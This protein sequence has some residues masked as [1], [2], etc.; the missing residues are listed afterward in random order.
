MSNAVHEVKRRHANGM[1]LHKTPTKYVNLVDFG[2]VLADE[3][4]LGLEKNTKFMDAE[5]EADDNS[6]IMEDILDEVSMRLYGIL[7]LEECR[8]KKDDDK[9]I[10][11]V[12]VNSKTVI[13]TIKDTPKKKDILTS[14]T[15]KV[16]AEADLEANPGFLW[17]AAPLAQKDKFWGL[18]EDDLRSEIIKTFKSRIERM[19]RKERP[20]PEPIVAA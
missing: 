7:D 3:F 20:I 11:A 8:L 9:N 5:L 13:K 12:F 10:T 14:M 1:T 18:F 4:V 19:L 17:S 2:M 16:V 15:G 6:S